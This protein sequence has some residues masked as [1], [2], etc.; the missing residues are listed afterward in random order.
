MP[1]GIS[2]TKC[3]TQSEGEASGSRLTLVAIGCGEFWAAPLLS[4]CDLKKREPLPLPALVSPAAKAV[5]A[6]KR[7]ASR[8]SLNATRRGPLPIG[9]RRTFSLVMDNKCDR[10][11]AYQSGERRTRRIDKGAEAPLRQNPYWPLSA[12]AE[13]ASWRRADFRRGSPASGTADHSRRPACPAPP[14][15]RQRRSGPGSAGRS[16]N[17]ATLP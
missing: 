4:F 11:G 17:H 13:D 2:S 15:F 10:R 16:P 6:A 5:R 1:E 3:L 14:G 8:L 9:W 7:L 12:T